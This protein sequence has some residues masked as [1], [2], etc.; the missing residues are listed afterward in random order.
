MWHLTLF[1][2]CG[3]VVITCTRKGRK[4]FLIKKMVECEGGS[5]QEDNTSTNTALAADLDI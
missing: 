1:G 4:K 2:L 3:P 5:L